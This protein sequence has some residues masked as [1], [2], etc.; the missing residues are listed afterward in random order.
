MHER[1]FL[2]NEVEFRIEKHNHK[3]LFLTFHRWIRVL[4]APE[5]LIAIV[6]RRRIDIETA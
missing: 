2:R 6:K 5:L 1:F 3:Y 4:N